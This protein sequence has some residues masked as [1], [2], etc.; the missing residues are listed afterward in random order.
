MHRSIDRKRHRCLRPVDGVHV[1]LIDGNRQT[2]GLEVLH[3]TGIP[4]G[5]DARSE[6]KRGLLSRGPELL[7]H[8]AC[9]ALSRIHLTADLQNETIERREISALART[10]IDPR[11]GVHPQNVGCASLT[12][13]PARNGCWPRVLPTGPDHDPDWMQ[14]TQRGG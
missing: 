13:T 8:T 14:E 9:G 5:V 10:S 12:V 7:H 4:K 11:R 3:G 6:R 1:P 2:G